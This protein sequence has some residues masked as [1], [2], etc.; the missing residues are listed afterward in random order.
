MHLIDIIVWVNEEFETW[1]SNSIDCYQPID[2]E[3]QLLMS[4]FEWTEDL[5]IN[6]ETQLFRYQLI[7]DNE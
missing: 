4:L 7:N 2:E 6:Y 3:E 5:E 1:L